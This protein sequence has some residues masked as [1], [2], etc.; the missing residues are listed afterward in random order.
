MS[1]DKPESYFEDSPEPLPPEP[2]PDLWPVDLGEDA[3]PFAGDIGGLR[4]RP[5]MYPPGT[6]TIVVKR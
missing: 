6:R 1:T 2:L 5:R 3:P 4:P